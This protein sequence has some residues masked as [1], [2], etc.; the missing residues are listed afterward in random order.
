MVTG[1]PTYSLDGDT[2]GLPKT[3]RSSIPYEI[4]ALASREAW[5]VGNGSY[6][7]TCRQTWGEASRWVRDMV[8]EVSVIMP[9]STPL[10]KRH[11]PEPMAYG[12]QDGRIQFCTLIDQQ[13]QFGNATDGL[14]RDVLTNWPETDYARYRATFESC[15]W[16]I[17]DETAS[18]LGLPSMATV[19]AGAGAY[20][21]AIELYRY[22]IRSRQTYAREQAIPGPNVGAN[23]GFFTVTTPPKTIPY[24]VPIRNVSFANVQYKWLRVPIG[25]PPPFGWTPADP[26]NPWPPAFNPAALDVTKLRARDA[27]I[28]CVN[29]AWFDA[30]AGDGYAW[31]PGTLLFA[32][33]DDSKRYYD[34]AGDYVNDV[35]VNF[36]YKEGG[37]NKFLSASGEWVLATADVTP[38]DGKKGTTDGKTLHRAAAFD[39]LFRYAA[40]STISATPGF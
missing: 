25:W 7:I 11:I 39:D 37:W 4:D 30:A 38:G 40:T 2:S 26:S 22:V 35:V 19:Q 17:L 1:M 24:G 9:G 18:V 20:A 27:Y 14:L 8:G 12:D 36:K 16:T 28:G 29:N 32:G 23:L 31:A 34:A 33:Y 3:R 5:G 21:G 15:P 6:T 13:D 10:L